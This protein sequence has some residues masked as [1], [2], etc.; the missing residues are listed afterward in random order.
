MKVN[1]FFKPWPL[2]LIYIKMLGPMLNELVKSNVI[3]DFLMDLGLSR[4]WKPRMFF[5]RRKAMLR[6]RGI[7]LPKIRLVEVPSA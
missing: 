5:P 2:P 1:H 4:P 6:R 3:L 7:F